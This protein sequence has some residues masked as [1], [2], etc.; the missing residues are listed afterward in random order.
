MPYYE[1]VDIGASLRPDGIDPERFWSDMT[2]VLSDLLSFGYLRSAV[3][4]G[5]G[6]I[7]SVHMDRLARRFWVLRKYLPGDLCDADVIVINGVRCRNPLGLAL[8]M[9]DSDLTHRIDPQRLYYPVHGDLN[10]RNIL[11]TE[12][13]YRVIDPRGTIHHWDPAYDIAKLL[14][15]LTVWDAAMRRG[16]NIGRGRE[17][18]IGVRG[19]RYQGYRNAASQLVPQLRSLSGFGEL[20]AGDSGWESRVL[21]GHAFHTLAEAAC[22]LSAAKKRTGEAGDCQFTPLE[23]AVGHYL[24]GVLFLED[25]VRQLEMEG[26][27]DTEATLSLLD[28]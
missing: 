21:L 5:V 7:N 1:S 9:A 15:S 27:I 13:R 19:G 28:L 22:R 8:A 25:A 17:W 23:L 24:Y 2:Q 18:S 14:F 6:H 26:A 11:V 12:D 20:T 3:S 10:M 16:F 4:V